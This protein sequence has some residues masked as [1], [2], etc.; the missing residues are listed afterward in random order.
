[1]DKKPILACIALLL[2]FAAPFVVAAP[3]THTIVLVRHG[4]YVPDPNAD[5]QLGPGLSPLGVAQ[6]HLAGARLAALPKRVDGLYVSPLQRARDSAAAMAD[7][8]PARTFEVVADLAECTPPA[9]GMTPASAAETQAQAGCRTQLDR[10]YTRFF[11]AANNV[12]RTDMLVCHGNVIRYLV[13]RALGVDTTSW[14]AMSVGHASITTIRIEADGTMR[15]IAV[16]DVGHLP[17][18][19][20]TGALGDPERTL[21]LPPP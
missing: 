21:A 11:K 10:A 7:D 9:R 2:S 8:F 18:T 15:V 14:I 19:L 3:A 1:M 13:T 16:G 12:E 20:R 4:N 5:P 6:A 17:P